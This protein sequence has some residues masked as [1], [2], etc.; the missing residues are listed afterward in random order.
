MTSSH[1]GYAHVADL[2][3]DLAADARINADLRNRLSNLHTTM[4]ASSPD[5]GDADMMLIGQALSFVSTK[6][7]PGNA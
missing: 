7:A 3:E 6:K 1:D 5:L 2:C 4:D